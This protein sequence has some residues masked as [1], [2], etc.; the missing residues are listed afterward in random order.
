M[1]AA[2]KKD[3]LIKKTAIPKIIFKNLIFS[4][5]I[6]RIRVIPIINNKYGENNLVVSKEIISDIFFK[7]NKDPDIFPAS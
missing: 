1:I 5:K 6:I 3:K 2:I 4:F 7:P